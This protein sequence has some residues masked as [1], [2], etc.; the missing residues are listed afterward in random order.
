MTKPFNRRQG[1]TDVVCNKK[2]KKKKKK[3]RKTVL[4]ILHCF[5]LRIIQRRCKYQI[6]EELLFIYLLA[7]TA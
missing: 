7:F 5:Y 4:K 1:E 6:I 2:K 3:K